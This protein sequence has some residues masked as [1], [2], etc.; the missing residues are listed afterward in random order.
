MLLFIQELCKTSFVPSVWLNKA[1]IKVNTVSTPFQREYSWTLTLIYVLWLN[2]FVI[3]NLLKLQGHQSK[4][5]ITFHVFSWWNQNH[6]IACWRKMWMDSHHFP[7]HPTPFLT[8][9]FILF[10]IFFVNIFWLYGLSKC[11]YTEQSQSMISSSKPIL[12]IKPEFHTR[13]IKFDRTRKSI[14][15]QR[16]EGWV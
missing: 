16:G 11:T 5:N 3:I 7:S 15:P 4:Q 10:H 2:D 12:K 9:A 14:T 13:C 1:L 6:R 8:R